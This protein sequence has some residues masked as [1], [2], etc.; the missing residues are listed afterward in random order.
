MP[1][2]ETWCLGRE[3]SSIG[4]AGYCTLCRCRANV[5]KHDLSPFLIY[6]HLWASSPVCHSSSLQSFE[7]WNLEHRRNWN[8][9]KNVLFNKLCP[10][11]P[12]TGDCSNYFK[13]IFS[14]HHNKVRFSLIQQMFI[15]HW[16]LQYILKLPPLNQ[17]MKLRH[18]VSDR[19]SQSWC[20]T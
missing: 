14:F 16:A 3:K 15:V 2:W 4:R 12:G 6:Y 7:V 8:T 13:C 9:I 10:F 17:K 5:S 11:S 20:E 19:G 18:K 1:K